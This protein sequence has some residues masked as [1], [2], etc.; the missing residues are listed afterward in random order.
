MK[1]YSAASVPELEELEGEAISGSWSLKVADMA[2]QDVGKLN[3]WSLKII[4]Q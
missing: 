2:A 1:T 3:R 4:P